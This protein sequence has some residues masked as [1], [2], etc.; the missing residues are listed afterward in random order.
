MTPESKLKKDIKAHVEG[1]GGHYTPVTGGPYG[2]PGEPDG[3]VCYKGMYVA[4]EAKTYE[5]TQ[6]TIQK[7]RQKQIEAAGGIYIL[8]RS[9]EDVAKILDEIDVITSVDA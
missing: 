5:G 4:V 1:R 2:R 3:I 8:A 6:S 9:V 7:L